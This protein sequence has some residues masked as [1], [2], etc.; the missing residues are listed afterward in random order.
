MTT[1]TKSIAVFDSD[2]HIV[3]PPEIWESYLD[4][5]FRVLG[6]QA[7]WRHDGETNSYLKINGE[8]V[9]DTMNPNL[10]RH[11]I[12][13]PGMS[14]DDDRRIGCER[15]ASDEPRRVGSS[16]TAGRYGFDGY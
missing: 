3:E 7:L 4:P 5:E 9:R 11:A 2:Q 1:S 13:R 10:P 6:K 14:W 16:C 15:E 12:W 8:V